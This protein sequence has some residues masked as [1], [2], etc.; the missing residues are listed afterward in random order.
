MKEFVNQKQTR[1][2]TGM[3]EED[4]FSLRN[5]DNLGI[6]GSHVNTVKEMRSKKEEE[7]MS[8]EG[9]TFLAATFLSAS[10]PS[11]SRCRNPQDP[12]A[13]RFTG[14]PL[15]ALLQLINRKKKLNYLPTAGDT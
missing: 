4:D 3:I 14:V 15:S 11:D 12:K 1:P 8:R 2:T 10:G 7:V 9:S 13:E 5:Y 6:D